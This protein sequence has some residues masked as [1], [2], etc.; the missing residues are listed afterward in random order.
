MAVFEGS[1]Y[2]ETALFDFMEQTPMFRIRR[3]AS[4]NLSDSSTYRFQLGDRI[5]SIAHK[6]YGNAQLYWA[7]LDANTQYFSE[8]EI[9]VGDLLVIPAYQEVLKHAV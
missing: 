9:K 7:I 6:L 8:I 1:R 5:D 3:P 4:F 2:L